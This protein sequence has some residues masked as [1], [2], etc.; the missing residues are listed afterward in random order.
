[1]V[2]FSHAWS[3]PFKHVLKAMEAFVER[4]PDGSPPVY[5]WFDVFSI[6]QHSGQKKTQTWWRDTFETGIG[7]IGRTVMMLSPWDN[8]ITLTRSWCLFELLCTHRERARFDIC[9]GKDEWLRFRAELMNDTE[10]VLEAFAQIDVEKARA[11]EKKDQEMIL[12]EAR[13]YGIDKLNCEVVKELRRLIIEE[14]EAMAWEQNLTNWW[15]ASEDAEV[16]APGTPRSG[17]QEQKDTI[18]KAYKVALLFKE[19]GTKELLGRS[20]KLLKKVV[21]MSTKVYGQADKQTLGALTNYASCLSELG[22]P[23]Q[24]M[25]AA[26][27]Y[28]DI[29]Q[30]H[31]DHMAAA[32]GGSSSA[33]TSCGLTSSTLDVD[34]DRASTGGVRHVRAQH[35]D[36]LLATMAARLASMEPT[37][38]QT[39]RKLADVVEQ[40]RASGLAELELLK[41][42]LALAVAHKNLGERQP[43]I[44]LFTEIEQKMIKKGTPRAYTSLV[45]KGHLGLL[46]DESDPMKSR[47]LKEAIEGLKATRGE[48]HPTT[49]KF[50]ALAGA[51]G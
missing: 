38:V 41:A 22:S 4:Q 39:K 11:T 9:M 47:S 48:D 13:D 24:K 45:A 16:V 27:T 7:R 6:D 1:M 43:A 29:E 34:L 36:E 25:E 17:G 2:F 26:Q 15:T 44:A 33:L 35:S 46:L 20:C 3:F 28:Q 31:R 30:C 49:Q 21:D 50:I 37:P 12:A 51:A 32:A 10:T 19:L 8:P 42:Q 23:Q 18:E 5:F 14:V 40:M